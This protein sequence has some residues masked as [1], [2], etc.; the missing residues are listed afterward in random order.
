MKNR[1]SAFTLIEL[2]VV[3]AIIAILA[4]LL[5]PALAKAKQKAQQTACISNL[6]QIGIAFNVYVGDYED[7]MPAPGSRTAL[8]PQPEDWIWWQVSVV[9]GRP[10]VRDVNRSVIAPYIGGF[11]QNLLRCAA[12][13]AA[14]KREAAWKANTSVEQYLYSYSLNSFNDNGMASSIN[15]GRTAIKLNT[16]GK[17]KNPS[18]K[19]MIAEER[20]E[21]SD[22]PGNSI[23]DDGRWVPP[24]N[25]LTSR[26]AGK[27]DV[28]F[29]DS[30]VEKV[31][32]AYGQL[33]ENYDPQY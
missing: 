5:L 21:S 27:A 25:T 1:H 20:G 9:G 2:L 18:Q 26:H 30:H 3:I 31:T 10:S 4:G 19:I 23:I 32:P 14:L 6:R 33:R 13:K 24:G 12:D 16:L 28:A 22:G 7:V 17:V 15:V 8:G 29:A 11:N